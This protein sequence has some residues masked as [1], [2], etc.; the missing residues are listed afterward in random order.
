ME[1]LEMKDVLPTV[2]QVLEAY[3]DES[4]INDGDPIC[5]AAGWVASSRQWKLFEERWQRA[6]S[7]VVFHTRSRNPR[8]HPP[9]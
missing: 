3:L 5:V 6:S 1:E 4:G 8:L 7:G 2:P 9:N